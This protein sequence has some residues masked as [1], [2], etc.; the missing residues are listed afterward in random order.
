M[1]D[2][3]GG[4]ER[5]LRRIPILE[6]SLYGFRPKWGPDRQPPPVPHF[7]DLVLYSLVDVHRRDE[8]P[9]YDSYG[10]EWTEHR[11]LNLNPG[12]GKMVDVDG[13]CLL[14]SSPSSLPFGSLY[15]P[16]VIQIALSASDDASFL[17]KLRQLSITVSPGRAYLCIFV[18]TLLCCCCCCC[19]FCFILFLISL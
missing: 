18:M 11:G 10:H 15:R 2:G 12:Q 9:K 8:M 13:V 7:W 1:N 5:S 16:C 19:C 3:G 14:S 17:L 6:I 4:E